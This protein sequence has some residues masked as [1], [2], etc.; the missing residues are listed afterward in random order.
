MKII[1]AHL[2]TSFKRKDFIETAKGIRNKF[3]IEEL[4]KN[5]KTN[6]I[7]CVISITSDRTNPTPLEYNFIINLAKKYRNIFGVVGINPKKI[8]KN[9][10]KKIEEGIKLG[11]IKGLKVYP[12]YYY[13]YPHDKVYYKFYKVAERYK[14]PVIIHC[15]DT[16][17]KEALV[18]YAHPINVDEVAVNFPKVNF[19]IAHLGNPWITDAAEVIYKNENVYTDLSGLCIG[20]DISS[21]TKTK[22]R[23]ALDYIDNYDKIIY[24]SD[25]PLVNMKSYIKIIK[26]IIPRQYREKVF[27]ENAKKLFRL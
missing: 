13:T 22:V 25:W 26:S 9:S 6:N 2:H 24:G 12:G 23:E 15:G 17:K 8:D 20:K 14:I 4:E 1:D 7:E 27:Y 18:K 21:F 3:T 10:I 11:L 19:I 16:Y 5:L